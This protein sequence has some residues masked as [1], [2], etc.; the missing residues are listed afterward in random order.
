MGWLQWDDYNWDQNGERFVLRLMNNE[1]YFMS[2]LNLLRWRWAHFH[3]HKM[4][5]FVAMVLMNN[6]L[7]QRLTSHHMIYF[8]SR[9]YII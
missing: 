4:S 1:S 7:E 8:G 2:Y 5:P 3:G 9:Q 6:K